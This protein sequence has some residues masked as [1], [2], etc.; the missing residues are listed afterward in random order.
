MTSDD[1]GVLVDADAEQ[2]RILVHCTEQPADAPS[3]GGRDS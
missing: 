2:P 3:L 1:R